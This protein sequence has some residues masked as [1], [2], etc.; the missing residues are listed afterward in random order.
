LPNL[1][2]FNLKG[3]VVHHLEVSGLDLML[4]V[5]YGVTYTAFLLFTASLIFHRRDFR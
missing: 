2:R 3:H 1:E 4:I 5:A